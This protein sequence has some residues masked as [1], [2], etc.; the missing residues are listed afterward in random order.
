ML[1][2]WF[3]KGTFWVSERRLVDQ[4]NTICWNRCMTKAEIEELEREIS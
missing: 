3:I 4:A 1:G 2:L